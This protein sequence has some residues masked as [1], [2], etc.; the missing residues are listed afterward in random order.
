[1]EAIFEFVIEFIF[2][3]IFGVVD[4]TTK[5]HKKVIRRTIITVFAISL[6]VFFIA[7][8]ILGETGGKSV[9]GLV[10]I[11]LLPIELIIMTVIFIISKLK[12]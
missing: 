6:F 2:E 7:I 11:S 8:P 1:M 4:E 12:K 9:L 10:L 5:K 3:V